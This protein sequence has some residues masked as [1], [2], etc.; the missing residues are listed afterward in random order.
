MKPTEAATATSQRCQLSRHRLGIGRHTSIRFEL[1]DQVSLSREVEVRRPRQRL[2]LHPRAAPPRDLKLIC[3][4]SRIITH[5]CTT[6]CDQ[7]AE[8]PWVALA[9]HADVGELFICFVGGHGGDKYRSSTPALISTRR[10]GEG[11]RHQDGQAG[12]VHHRLSHLRGSLLMDVQSGRLRLSSRLPCR[13]DR[14][15]GFVDRR[16]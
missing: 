10:E 14:R 11:N 3:D 7:I 5:P 8:P 6:S 12:S 15:G 2:P 9:I 4:L 16:L 13:G 1:H